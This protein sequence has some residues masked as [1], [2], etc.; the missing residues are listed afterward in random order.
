VTFTR[1][2]LLDDRHG[3]SKVRAL[4]IGG[5]GFIGRPLCAW[6]GERNHS[7]RLLTRDPER[8]RRLVRGIEQAVAWDGS[9]AEPAL[10]AFAG[11]DAI[12]NLAG[13]SIGGRATP[14]RMRAVRESR[15]GGTARL[16]DAL[17]RL[18][19][20]PALLINASAS[21]YYGDRGDVV[22]DED[23]P[24]GDDFMARLCRDWE[25][26]ALR[27][28]GLGLK[29][30]RLRTGLVLDRTGGALGRLLPLFRLGLGG[31]LGSG[32]QWWP[33][34]A[35]PD[36]VALIGFLLEHPYSGAVVAAAPEAVRQRTFAAA[37]FAA[38]R[39]CPHRALP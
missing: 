24:P 29:V 27:A 22:L 2:L 16:V 37:C 30:V 9:G 33:W 12:V 11:I 25:A 39:S 34:I 21:G 38:L 20:R 31:P 19:S 14:A 8:A 36:L 35:R 15:V 18:P 6:L 5:T 7:V 1:A 26:E 10:E 23:S 32:R 13:E 28:E 17:K 4:I 3:S